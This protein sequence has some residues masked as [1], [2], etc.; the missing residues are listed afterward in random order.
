[1]FNYLQLASTYIINTNL[2]TVLPS[3]LFKLE[4]LSITHLTKDNNSKGLRTRRMMMTKT[5]LLVSVSV[6]VIIINSIM[7]VTWVPSL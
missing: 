7:Y 5:E 1:M 2:A 4:K 6:S 3:Y